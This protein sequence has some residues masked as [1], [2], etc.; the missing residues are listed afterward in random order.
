MAMTSERAPRPPS[1]GGG[2]TLVE[3]LIALIVIGLVASIAIPAFFERSEVTL[4]SACRLLA[5]DLRAAQNRAA[6]LQT[7]VRIQFPADGDGYMA[8][9]EEGNTLEAPGGG[10]EF[11]RKY[12]RDAVFEGVRISHVECGPM[13]RIV[14]DE[15]GRAPEGG[16]VVVSYRQDSRWVIVHKGD[17]LVEV[18]DLVQPWMERED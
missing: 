3:L 14:Y 2:F 12:S 4:D 17:G 10:G 5:E 6:Y 9:D 1:K 13:R 18:P 16:K 11:L 15:N 7:E 8:V